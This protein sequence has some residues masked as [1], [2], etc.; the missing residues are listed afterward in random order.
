[1]RWL[2]PTARLSLRL[3]AWAGALAALAIA[4]SSACGGAADDHPADGGAEGATPPP[5]AGAEGGVASPD[6]ASAAAE[7]EASAPPPARTSVVWARCFAAWGGGDDVHVAVDGAHDVVLA[8]IF[9]GTASFGGD[10][11]TSAGGADV[12]VAKLDPT[13]KHLW[14][15]RF[16]GPSDQLANDVAV[17]ASGAIVLGGLYYHSIDFGGGPLP[18]V[19]ATLTWYVAKLDPWGGYVFAQ[20]PESGVG[21]VAGVAADPSGGVA[22]VGTRDTSSYVGAF[23]G[24]GKLRW[25]RTFPGTSARLVGTDGAGDLIVAGILRQAS[26]FGGDDLLAAGGDDVFFAKLDAAGK[27][28]ASARYGDEEDQAPY[29]LSVRP[30]GSFAIGGEFSGAMDFGGG[31]VASSGLGDVFV[32]RFDAAARSASS[33][34]FGDSDVAADAPLFGGL[35]LLASGEIVFGGAFTG[36][37]DFGGGAASSTT[38]AAYLVELDAKDAYRWSRTYGDARYQIATDVAIDPADPDAWVVAMDIGQPT[39]FGAGPIGAAREICAVKFHR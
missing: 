13:G 1:M 35:G 17:D 33:R 31:R 27:H 6:D 24:A 15:K 12:F 9:S 20:Q 29:A 10:V 38:S 4:P 32:A 16:G 2:A 30:D 39:D 36:T 14:S 21:S 5:D 8:G 23:D 25:S 18:D 11:L 28:L 37:V 26:N 34:A 19:G 7:A 22:V 3:A